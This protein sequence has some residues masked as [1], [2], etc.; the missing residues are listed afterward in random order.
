MPISSPTPSSTLDDLSPELLPPVDA[1]LAIE[2]REL[3]V[4]G[5]EVGTV[6]VLLVVEVDAVLDV[7]V[8]L[9]PV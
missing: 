6:L 7:L 3:A 1:G 2:V 4:C 9:D 5:G 8:G